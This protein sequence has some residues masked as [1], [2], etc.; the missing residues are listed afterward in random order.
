MTFE[1][2]PLPYDESALEPHISAQTLSYH[3]GKHHA[4]YVKKLNNA[5]ENTDYSGLGLE[6]IIK[7]SH[8]DEDASVF[9]NAAQVWNHDRYWESMSPTP[10]AKPTGDFMKAIEKDF[11]SFDAMVDKLKS[12][13]ASLFGSGWVWLVHDG[14][15][16]RI[17]GTSNAETPIAEGT[18]ALLTIDVWEHAYYLDFQNDRPSY[19]DVYF[20]KLVDWSHAEKAF[21]DLNA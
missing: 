14:G 20:D 4:G 12:A 8:A 9:N 21:N 5:I 6:E 17:V 15:Q 7:K 10:S 13:A 3:Y 16:L 1:L 19:I 18:D 2:K 11:G